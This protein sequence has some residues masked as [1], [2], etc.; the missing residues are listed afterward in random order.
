MP[1]YIPDGYSAVTPRL[2]VDDLE[3]M[4]TFL[5]EAFAATGEFIYDQSPVEM[6]VDGALLLVSSS[7]IRPAT[8]S[9]FYLYVADT[10]ATFASALAAGAIS[11]EEP[12]DLPYGDR[13][14][15][16]ED[17]FGNT[18]QIATPIT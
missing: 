2:F 1:A 16:V 9:A 15:M 4:T 8:T 6:W 18:W 7:S 13:R 3:R 5:R 10:D 11:M 12:R 14:A 17:P